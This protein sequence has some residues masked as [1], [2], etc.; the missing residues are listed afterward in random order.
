MKG[1]RILKYEMVNADGSRAYPM[2]PSRWH[3][4]K[5]GLLSLRYRSRWGRDNFP[6]PDFVAVG[7]GQWRYRAALPVDA[8]THVV[9]L[10]EGGT[11]L[12]CLLFHGQ[13]VFFKLDHLMPTGS[14]KDRGASLLMTKAK[15]LG[16][17]SVVEDSSGNAGCAVAAYSAAAGIRCEI[18]V[19]EA[20]SLAKL[21]Q[22]AAYGAKIHKVKGDRTATANE[23][24]AAAK[25]RFYASHVW[26]PFFFEGT[27]TCAFEIA[28]QM[29]W[30]A[31]SAVI[32]PL[33]NGSLLLGL[34]FGFSQLYEAGLI[35]H[36]PRL[37]GVQAA[38]CAP[39]LGARRHGEI[40]WDGA[41]LGG[42]T[43]A[44]GIAIP[45]P[46]RWREIL[47][48]VA[49]S[50]GDLISVSE[51]E[52]HQAMAWLVKQG[53]FVEPTSA[54]A[55]AGMKQWLQIASQSEREPVVILTG[56]GLKASSKVADMVS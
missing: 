38:E 51:S 32:A 37:I 12:E 22:L 56:H 35:A 47:R 49:Q 23:A 31:P 50:S 19:P 33:G 20:T 8:S 41:G 45:Y 42:E 16:V 28:E 11:P 6:T 27:K 13:S 2:E 3:D 14:Y 26:N 10:G 44:E 46:L 21:Y 18:Y 29:G 5:G 24:A 25:G 48:V 34:F 43:V 4:E 40:F 30:R 55:V 39:L 54:V 53:L 15:E 17:E 7:C 1:W 52:I 9:S 36:L